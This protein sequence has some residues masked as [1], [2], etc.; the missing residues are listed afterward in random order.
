[1]LR[2]GVT[3]Y[4]GGEF[5]TVN[6]SACKKFAAINLI[7]GACDTNG[8]QYVGSFISNPFVTINADLG[9]TGTVNAIATY[10]NFLA[11]GGSFGAPTNILRGRGLVIKDQSTG[12]LY[13][14]YVNGT[15]NSLV[16]KD[17]GADVYLYVG[18]DFDYINYGF[19]GAST[20]SGLRVSTNGLTKISL[21]LIADGFAN[22]SIDADFSSMVAAMFNDI[23]VVNSIAVKG[24]AIYV[25]G[26]FH[27]KSGATLLCR[28]LAC[29]AANGTL[30]ATW[31]PVVG[32][33]INTL[34]I[35]GDYLYCG[36]QFRSYHTAAQFYTA[37]RPASDFYNAMAFQ[38]TVPTAP[39]ILDT[40]KPVINGPVSKFAFHDA[41]ASSYVYCYGSFTIVNGKNVGYVAALQKAYKD[42]FISSTADSV[43]WNVKLQNGPS[44][45]NNA[46]ERYGNSIIVGG[47]FLS[48]NN[49][50]R[51][52]LARVNGVG[53]TLLTTVQLS[54]VMFDFGAQVCSGG[55]ALMM[56]YTNF[57]SATAYPGPYGTV[58]E[59]TFPIISR[60]FTGYS[61]GELVKFF[62]KRKS[63]NETFKKNINVL[64]WKINFNR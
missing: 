5:T 53:E 30:V 2:S 37:P 25:G 34:A 43:F 7:G 40:W 59:T 1:M 24:T 17:E 62:I 47:N 36:G 16:V 8:L 54:S 22:S 41:V 29:I 23:A 55:A 13:P 35:D 10:G 49:Q 38:L 51:N 56:D 58:N 57:V 61:A 4:V 60:G 52:Y 6:G 42:S 26:D 9:D 21:T 46:L 33:T 3:L 18:G 32:G 44:L 12:A 11:I 39:L 63:T 45:I 20:I 15:V 19:Q 50:A 27:V 48:T 14:F 28:G 31:S 64:G